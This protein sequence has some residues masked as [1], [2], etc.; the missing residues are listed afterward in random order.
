MNE[1]DYLAGHIERGSKEEEAIANAKQRREA[2]DEH[3]T[4]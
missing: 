2:K 1:I 4:E 3:D